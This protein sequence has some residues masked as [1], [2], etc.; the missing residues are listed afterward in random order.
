M[1]ILNLKP[2]VCVFPFQT[3]REAIGRHAADFG[4]QL[5]KQNNV[6]LIIDGKTLKYA[7]SC[8]LRMEFLDLCI[9]CKVVMCCRVSPIQ[10][11]DVVDLVASNTNSVTLAIG[12]GANDVAMIQ[13]AHVG[14]GISGVEGLQAAC[15]SD[16]SI[17]QFRFLLRLLLVHGSWN[18]SRMCKLI[19]YSFYKNVCLYVI[20]LWFAIYSGWSGQILFERW[21]IGLYNVLFTALPPFAMGMFDKVCSADVM[22]KYPLLYQPSQ[23]AQL[24]NVKVFWVW[25]GNAVMHSLILFWLP[26]LSY[27][28][29]IVWPNGRNGGYLVLGNMVYTVSGHVGLKRRHRPNL[30]RLPFAVRRGDGVP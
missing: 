8:D 21:T 1:V 25:I 26:M 27:G 16:Y 22:L 20:E 7:L 28:T 10:K 15:A 13:K 4:E 2:S 23:N 3:T 29:E 24:L 17:A 19:L 30:C 6:A 5:R 11:A 12:D 9:S 14:V 18:Y